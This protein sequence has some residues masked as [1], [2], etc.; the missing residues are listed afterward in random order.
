[1][2]KIKPLV[3]IF[4]LVLL[5]WLV[6]LRELLAALSKLTI[7]SVVLLLG[8]SVVLILVSAVKWRCF[9]ESGQQEVSLVRL[10]KLYLVGYFVNLMLP[11]YFGG[12][13]VRSWYAGK[14]HGQHAAATATILERYTGLVAMLTLAFI[15]VWLVDS[16]TPQVEVAVVLCAVGLVVGTFMVLA[17]DRLPV[18]GILGRHKALSGHFDKIRRCLLVAGRNR[19]LI[20]KALMLSFLYHSLTVLNT[21]VAAD[22]VG[23]H[24]PPVWDLFVVLPLILLIGSLPISPSGLG[25]Q[26]GAFF[27]FLTG[28]GATP[29]QALGVGVVLRAKGYVLAL[30]GGVVWLGLKNEERM[31][32][33]ESGKA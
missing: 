17:A 11:S 3:A 30:L 20:A 7:T 14:Q 29:A 23:W 12:D 6:D 21:V 13:V 32:S 9:L 1:M 31:N 22:A 24:N 16:A 19:S 15:F 18:I 27:F 10:F 26:E 4:M 8:I 5:V 25:I 28:V 2:R 33:S